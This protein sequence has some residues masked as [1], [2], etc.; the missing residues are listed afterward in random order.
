MNQLLVSIR[1]YIAFTILTGLIYTLLIT[2][3]AGC[4]FPKQSKGSLVVHNGKVV[5][6]ELIGRQFTGDLYFHS[7]P[8]AVY[9]NPLPSGASNLSVVSL[10]L[11]DSVDLRK[12]KFQK[13]NGLS[14]DASVPLDMLF[15][16]GSGLDPHISPRAARLQIDRVAAA[17][18]FTDA[19]KHVLDS[20]VE[21]SVE[22]RQI[23]ILGDPRVN[24]LKLN[25][26]MD[27]MEIGK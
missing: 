26:A 11:K 12:R 3:I 10:R 21:H 15:A 20:I 18:H 13:E 14:G 7:R 17:H 4:F 9:Y 6:S 5:G 22:S 1:V 8:S 25:L 27:G 16:S 24:V 19:Q 2:V 23:G